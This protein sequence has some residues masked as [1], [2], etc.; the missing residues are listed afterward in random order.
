MESEAAREIPGQAT[1][2]PAGPILS[3]RGIWKSF[4]TKSVFRGL[5]LD[6][7]RG[8]ILALLGSSGCGKSVLLKLIIGLM[9]V[10]RGTILWDGMHVELASS[11]ELAA[12]RQ[13]VGMVFQGAAL[14][15]SL[16]VADNVAYGLNVQGGRRMKPADVWKN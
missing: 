7:E 2:A 13:R 9:S 12:V 8:E 4:G 15:D 3:L 16:S 11:K 5:D 14:F 6:I 1:A 10:D